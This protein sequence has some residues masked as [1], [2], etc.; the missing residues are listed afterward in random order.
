MDHPAKPK[1][2]RRPKYNGP[3]QPDVLNTVPLLPSN[4]NEMADELFY[5]GDYGHE[6][7]LN[8]FDYAN[9]TEAERRKKEGLCPRCGTKGYFDR[10]LTM[11]CPTHGPY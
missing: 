10:S 9:E 2:I 5:F 3:Q 4:Q 1:V 7:P 11:I 6:E 8:L